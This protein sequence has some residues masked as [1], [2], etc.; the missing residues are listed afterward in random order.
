MS[1]LLDLHL[2]PLDV[3]A[4][5]ASFPSAHPTRFVSIDGFLRPE[6]AREVAAAYPGFEEARK[7]GRE[8]RGVNEV[9]KVQV[10][11]PAHFPDPVLR[12]HRLLS[13]PEWLTV[14]SEITGIEK[15]LA[16]E[17]LSGGGMHLYAPGSHLDVHVDF[18]HILDRGLHRRLNILVFL[19]PDWR[20]EWGGQFELWDPEVR[21]LLRAFAPVMNRCV[22]FATNETSY[23]GVPKVRC[24]PGVSRNSFAAYYYTAISPEN[25][26]DASHSTVFRAR[27]D[28]KLKGA[29]WMPLERLSRRARERARELARRLRQ[30]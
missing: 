7:R 30:R 17:L 20:E 18:N 12:L 13:S 27:P 26:L 11:E 25:A 3:G 16:D 21:H 19:N 24:P 14:V 28:E 22:I 8:F 5:R 29:L 2:S 9:L 4:L 6:F 23:H 1:D 10:T 15:L